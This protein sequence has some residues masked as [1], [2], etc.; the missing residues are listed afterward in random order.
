MQNAMYAALAVSREE[1][2]PRFFRFL[3][4]KVQRYVVLTF[5]FPP[6]QVNVV[7]RVWKVINMPEVSPRGFGGYPGDDEF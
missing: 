6:T 7:Y 3:L 4:Q 5:R 1:L 2:S